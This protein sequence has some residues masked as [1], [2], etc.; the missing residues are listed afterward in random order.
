[1]ELWSD[2]RSEGK[3]FYFKSPPCE[4]FSSNVKMTFITIPYRFT[5]CK[6]YPNK[7][8]INEIFFIYV[9]LSLIGYAGQTKKLPQKCGSLVSSFGLLQYI[10]FFNNGEVII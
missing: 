10:F 8:L 1:M 2:D 5:Y 3:A 4:L 9:V 7:S 6:P